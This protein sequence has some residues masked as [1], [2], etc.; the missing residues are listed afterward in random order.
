MFRVED[1]FVGEP[2]KT[3]FLFSLAS[4]AWKLIDL[5]S[6]LILSSS[7]LEQLPTTSL[8]LVLQVGPQISASTIALPLQL[9]DIFTVAF[10][11]ISTRSPNKSH[12][13]ILAQNPNS[14]YS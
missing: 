10:T 4:I 2:E 12:H 14:G 3:R 1:L 7:F 11:F 9:L 13:P 8:F 6:I 5:V